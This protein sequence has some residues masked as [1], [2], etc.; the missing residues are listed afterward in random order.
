MRCGGGLL[1]YNASEFMNILGV[2]KGLVEKVVAVVMLSALVLGAFPVPFAVATDVVDDSELLID[3]QPVGSPIKGAGETKNFEFNIEGEAEDK[4]TGQTEEETTFSIDGNKF[5]CVSIS[6]ESLEGWSCDQPVAGWKIYASNGTTTLETVT[7]ENGY[8]TFT[9]DPGVWEVYEAEVFR[10]YP[11]VVYQNQTQLDGYESCQFDFTD[12]AT[13]LEANPAP[14]SKADVSCLFGNWHPT[15]KV[16]GVKWND[17]NADGLQNEGEKGV[18]GWKIYAQDRSED[19]QLLESTTDG[20]GYYEFDL[21]LE[22]DWNVYEENRSGWKQVVVTQNTYPLPRTGEEISSCEF[23]FNTNE[24][25]QSIEELAKVADNSLG[26]ENDEEIGLECS[27]Y[28]HFTPTVVVEPELPQRS[29]GSSSGTRVKDKTTPTPQVLGASTTV[30]ACG[31]YLTDYMR[32]GKEASSTEVTK[33]QIF[34]NAVGIKLAVTGA[35]DAATDAAVRKFQGD[36]K[37]EVL[38]PWYIAKLVPHEN[39]T[40]WVYQL[41]R[42]KINNMVCPGSEAYPVLN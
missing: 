2:S 1:F 22:G 14:L 27:F 7:D 29:R 23:N 24:T 41:T 16:S 19:G 32:M 35:F 4:Q 8:Y 31:M 33:L 6:D 30:P 9:V 39:P 26:S 5:E 37:A 20:L 13:V 10:W 15:F 40:G 3:G 36:H 25:E 18:S 17:I 28:N 11:I 38:T 12:P 34:L 21:E 42:W